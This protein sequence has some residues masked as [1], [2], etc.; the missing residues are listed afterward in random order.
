MPGR[1]ERIVAIQSEL[2]S[3]HLGLV[4]DGDTEVLKVFDVAGNLLLESDGVRLTDGSILIFDPIEVKDEELL[5]QSSIY[6]A[7]A[8]PVDSVEHFYFG[9]TSAS[10]RTA[11]EAWVVRPAKEPVFGEKAA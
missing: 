10:F 11:F 2:R 4:Y 6:G 8:V 9:D 1:I 7:V 5:G 3:L